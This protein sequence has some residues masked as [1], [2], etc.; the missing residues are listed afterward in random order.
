MYVPYRHLLDEAEGNSLSV[1]PSE[2]MDPKFMAVNTR[3]RVGWKQW[4]CCQ[5]VLL[6]NCRGAN[7]EEY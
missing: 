6:K 3:P 4:T 1:W 2:H 7:G 5:V